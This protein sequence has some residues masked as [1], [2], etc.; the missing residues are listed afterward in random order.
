MSD[1]AQTLPSTTTTTARILAVLL[2]HHLVTTAQ[3]RELLDDRPEDSGQLDDRLE[4]LHAQ[5]LT[6]RHMGAWH[7]TEEGLSIACAQPENT[8]LRPDRPPHSHTTMTLT[9]LG[10]A[11]CRQHRT[12]FHA[13][14]FTRQ[15]QVI[16]R[17]RDHHGHTPSWRLTPACA[18][19]TASRGHSSP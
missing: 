4:N 3:L 2:R 8:G 14:P 16:H 7:L 9:T 18:P 11:L 12:A 19:A 1:T 6:A 10:L 15:T 13:A 17:F 5:E